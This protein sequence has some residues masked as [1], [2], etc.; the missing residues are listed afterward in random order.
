MDFR[1]E[2]PL[3]AMEAVDHHRK[4]SVGFKPLKHEWVPCLISEEGEESHLRAAV[5][6]AERMD[7]I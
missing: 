2:R 1:D 6:F 7:G 3:V 4:E 5:A